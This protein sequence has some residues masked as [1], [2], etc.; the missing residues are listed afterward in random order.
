MWL[1]GPA[2]TGKTAIA[3]TVAET[4]KKDGTLAAS[5]FFS[6][7][8]GSENRYSKRCF[9]ATLTSHLAEHEALHGFKAQVH[10]SIEQNPAFFH[11][12]LREQAESLILAPLRSI[13]KP[14]GTASWPT[15]IIIDGLDEVK[16]QQFANGRRTNREDED[17]Q[18][19]ILDALF[20]LVTDPAFPFR[21][22]I[23]SR[24][25]HIIEDF[26]LSTAHDSTLKLF[27]DS[28][29][30]PDADITRFLEAKFAAVRRRCGISDHSWPGM[31][32]LDRIVEMSSG[33]FIVPAVIM[34]WLEGGVPQEQLEEVL[35][36][37]GVGTGPKNP[38]A[39]LDAVY[40]YI[41]GRAHNPEHDPHL[42]VK[43]ILC[44]TA[45]TRREMPGFPSNPPSTQFWRQFLED[46]TGELNYRMAPI[47][48]LI[49]VP[50]ADGGSSRITIY[51]KSLAD[52]LYSRTRCEHLYVKKGDYESFCADR[53]ALVLKSTSSVPLLLS[54]ATHAIL[55]DSRQ[56]PRCTAFHANF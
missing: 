6:S 53:I 49:A 38:F 12:R 56:G 37:E 10:K 21:I 4:C 54:V 51:H 26:F 13:R 9:I 8:S 24:P 47:A 55:D 11:R 2:G 19:E 30:D 16:A 7:F 50:P 22:F 18:L 35:K 52:F 27:L 1:S 32:V 20:T 39:T 29:Y 31:A 42:V 23:S 33:Q 28:K 14:C 46:K 25:E 48:S 34:R 15:G 41:L 36:L 45:S 3:G 40:R 44:I 43:W 17:D 5:F